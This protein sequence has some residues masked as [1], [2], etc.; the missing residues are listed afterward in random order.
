MRQVYRDGDTDIDAQGRAGHASA[1]AAHATQSVSASLP[2][3][4]RYLPA[5]QS[6]HAVADNGDAAYV[7][8]PHA[9]HAPLPVWASGEIVRAFYVVIVVIVCSHHLCP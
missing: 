6:T 2:V 3:D 1:P 4:A 8:A 5:A 9:T 7:P